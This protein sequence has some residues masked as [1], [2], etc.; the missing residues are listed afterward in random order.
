MEYVD[1]QLP[2]LNPR[3]ANNLSGFRG[4]SDSPDLKNARDPGANP[5]VDYPGLRT[6]NPKPRGPKPKSSSSSPQKQTTKAQS[7][8]L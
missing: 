3:H 8:Q 1:L 6:Q 7:E 4:L 5:F 2:A